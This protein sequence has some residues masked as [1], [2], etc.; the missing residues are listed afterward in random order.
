MM[1]FITF[2]S[3]IAV[4]VLLVCLYKAII[5]FGSGLQVLLSTLAEKN[6]VLGFAFL[7]LIFVLA[8]PFAVILT[9][10]LGYR[11][12]KNEE[13]LDDALRAELKKRR[14]KE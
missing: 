10:Y 8:F 6:G 7:I 1:E 12:K 14:N 3:L 5:L 2:L 9:I 4:G 11:D 13:K